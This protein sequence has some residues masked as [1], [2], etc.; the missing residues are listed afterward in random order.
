MNETQMKSLRF[1]KG[2]PSYSY[3][4]NMKNIKLSE[5][6]VLYGKEK[7]GNFNRGEF[8]EANTPVGLMNIS[9]CCYLN[10]L[11]QCYFL[12]GEFT[13]EILEAEEIVEI[14]KKKEKLIKNEYLLLNALK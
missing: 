3:L 9:N 12:M 1:Q 8:R 7:E 5:Y 13:R 2:V 6:Q 11:M 14:P 10:S 4:V